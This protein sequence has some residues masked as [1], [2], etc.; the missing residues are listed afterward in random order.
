MLWFDFRV[1][2]LVPGHHLEQGGPCRKAEMAV[3]P[4]EEF[5]AGIHLWHIS[6]HI[7]Q[8]AMSGICS[9]FIGAH[10]FFDLFES[11]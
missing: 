6:L 2:K 5:L 3:G 1:P 8:C 4:A 9:L 10:W 11:Q 7:A